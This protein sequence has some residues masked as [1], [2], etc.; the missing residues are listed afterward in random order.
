MAASPCTLPASSKEKHRD[1][2]KVKTNARNNVMLKLSS[3][4]VQN[5]RKGAKGMQRLLDEEEP[6][7]MVGEA[8]ERWADAHESLE[9]LLSEVEERRLQGRIHTAGYL[10][11]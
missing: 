7:D 3:L 2:T 5:I 10:P 11:P 9:D 8:F 6:E 4:I 1:R